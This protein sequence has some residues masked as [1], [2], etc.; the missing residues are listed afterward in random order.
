MSDTLT[1]FVGTGLSTCS[2]YMQLLKISVSTSRAPGTSLSP[3]STKTNEK[4]NKLDIKVKETL[5]KQESQNES[6]K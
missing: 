1:G 3:I 6:P 4:S 5:E 2:A